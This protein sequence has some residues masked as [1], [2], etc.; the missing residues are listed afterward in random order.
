[1]HFPK[2]QS[3]DSSSSHR[4]SLALANPALARERLQGPLT[5]RGGE[6]NR[7]LRL[8]GALL[9]GFLLALLAVRFLGRGLVVDIHV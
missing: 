2:R 8:A 7:V 1:M 9:L 6:G 4:D 3:H 5:A